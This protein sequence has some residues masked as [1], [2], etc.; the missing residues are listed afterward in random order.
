MNIL[1]KKQAVRKAVVK[2]GLL[3]KDGKNDYYRY[4]YLTA[5]QLKTIFNKLFAK[6]GLEFDPT[7]EEVQ[8][9][10]G[11]E[12]RPFGRLVKVRIYLYN[13]DQ[14]KEYAEAVFYGESISN[15]ATGLYGAVTGA[16]KSYLENTFLT[17]SEDDPD[18]NFP[19]PEPAEQSN[20]VRINEMT[21]AQKKI[22]DALPDQIKEEIVA[23]WGTLELNARE[24]SIILSKLQTEGKITA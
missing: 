21:P 9:F 14:P 5:N 8:H 13:V 11:T 23:R 6:H 10:P 3:K 15:N 2:M 1:E 24:A 22:I 7:I 17:T 4:Q 20:L 18:V 19:D 12:T 16:I